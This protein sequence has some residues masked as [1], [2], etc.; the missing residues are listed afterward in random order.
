MLSDE[1]VI[2]LAEAAA[3]LPR[4]RGKR[5]HAS[6][7]WRWARRGIAGVRLE[8]RRLGGQIVTSLEAI[9][10]FGDALAQRELPARGGNRVDL[11]R[12]TGEA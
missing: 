5:V 3:L 2:T 1:I 7:L 6:T 8:H 10:R 4:R 9:D 12:K 11:P